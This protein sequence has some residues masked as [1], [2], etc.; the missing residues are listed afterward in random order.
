MEEKDNCAK[1][2]EENNTIIISQYNYHKIEEK[3]ADEKL[4]NQKNI[5]IL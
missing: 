5:L 1:I 2:I 3:K 4:I